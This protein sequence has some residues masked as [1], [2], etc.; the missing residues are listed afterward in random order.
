M[1]FPFGR[2]KQKGRGVQAAAFWET[3]VLNRLNDYTLPGCGRTPMRHARRTRRHGK[4][5]SEIRI[6][7][8]ME[9]ILV[10]KASSGQG[11]IGLHAT[12]HSAMLLPF[13]R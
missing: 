6:S 2:Q 12:R 10:A 13:N 11:K 5:G 4:I 7:A 1:A 8:N 9:S 3:G